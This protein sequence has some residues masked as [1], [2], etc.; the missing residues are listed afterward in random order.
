MGSRTR[1]IS[2]GLDGTRER[3]MH[4]NIDRSNFFLARAMDFASFC[5]GEHSEM[6]FGVK[7]YGFA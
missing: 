5:G 6:Y 4:F 7:M 1:R 3:W 2:D